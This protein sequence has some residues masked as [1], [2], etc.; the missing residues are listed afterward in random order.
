MNKKYKVI[1]SYFAESKLDEIFLYYSIHA[2]GNIALKLIS[3]I[4]S[5]TR[6]LSENPNIGQKERLL[7]DRKE[8]YRYLIFK[9][10]KILYSVDSQQNLIKV[11]DVFDTRQNPKK[12]NAKR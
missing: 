4:I 1:W 6:N 12:I 8:T 10:Y 9:N 5:S 11:A 3:G 2:S 7:K